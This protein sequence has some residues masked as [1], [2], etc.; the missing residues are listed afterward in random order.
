MA[1]TPE[2]PVVLFRLPHETTLGFAAS[3]ANVYDTMTH[4]G[5]GEDPDRAD[6]EGF[7]PLFHA[8]NSGSVACVTALLQG[9]AQ[10]NKRIKADHPIL[11][12][13]VA[14]GRTDIVRALLRHNANPNLRPPDDISALHMAAS[15][16]N[17]EIVALLLAAGVALEPPHP[18]TPSAGDCP[19]RTAVLRGHTAVVRR[20]AG[21]LRNK[22]PG[23]SHLVPPA[24]GVGAESVDAVLALCCAGGGFFPIYG[25]FPFATGARAPTADQQGRLSYASRDRMRS[26]GVAYFNWG[27]RRF[28]GTSVGV[29][30][31]ETYAA[32]LAA[33]ERAWAPHRAH[34]PIGLA[35]EVH[36]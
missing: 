8:V 2:G 28:G 12:L 23:I 11:W 27:A 18:N 33:L 16:G 7:T 5:R 22:Y 1:T 32:D 4:L 13:A 31:P 20:L 9:G 6:D 17:E 14:M 26:A 30:N 10:P 29:L 24:A 36:M 19:L 25:K 34:L 3:N 15:D 35:F 21:A